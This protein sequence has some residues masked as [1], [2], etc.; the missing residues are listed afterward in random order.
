MDIWIYIP[1]KDLSS[2]FKPNRAWYSPWSPLQS[3]LEVNITLSFLDLMTDD[4]AVHQAKETLDSAYSLTPPF[5]WRKTF[6]AYPS[7]TYSIP[8]PALRL[9]ERMSTCTRTSSG[10]DLTHCIVGI[11]VTDFFKPWATPRTVAFEISKLL[12]CGLDKESMALLI[13]LC[14]NGVNPESLAVVIRELHREAS[15]LIFRKDLVDWECLL[16]KR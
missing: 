13:A 4:V 3:N 14:E 6:S 15:A 10:E 12:D 2:P 1:R 5:I 7:R 9:P 11:F 16:E 8:F